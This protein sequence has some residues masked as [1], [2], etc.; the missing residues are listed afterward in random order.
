MNQEAIDRLLIDLLRI[1]P[2]QRTQ[3]PKE[4]AA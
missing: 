2:E 1:P 4:A 3:N